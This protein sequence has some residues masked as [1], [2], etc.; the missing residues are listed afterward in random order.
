MHIG[1]L[2]VS[3]S[4]LLVLCSMP[5]RHRAR[6]SDENRKNAAAI[7]HDGAFSIDRQTLFPALDG[8]RIAALRVT[9]PDQTFEF[10]CNSQRIVSVN[11]NRA[12]EEIFLTLISQICNLPVNAHEPFT[13][14]GAPLMTLIISTQDGAQHTA[15]F[16]SGSS[17]HFAQVTSGSAGSL[18]YHQTDAWRIGTLM[19]AC[20]G[21]RIQDAYGNETPML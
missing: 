1:A 14:N 4:V 16:Y 18:A 2:C 3:I 5:A 10:H 8:S 7:M 21:T 19:M 12:D 20:E 17:A 9:T 11:G 13:P 15:H 6:I